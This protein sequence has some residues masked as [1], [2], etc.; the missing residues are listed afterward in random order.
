MQ[1]MTKNLTL[2][3]AEYDRPGPP[4][5][6]RGTRLNKTFRFERL[7]GAGVI[8]SSSRPD[9]APPKNNDKGFKGD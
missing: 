8:V 5:L 1:H 2:P 7:G 6:Q 3:A 9:N 4:M